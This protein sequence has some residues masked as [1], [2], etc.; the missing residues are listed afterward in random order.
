MNEPRAGDGGFIE[1]K[2]SRFVHAKSSQPIRFWAVNGP[3]GNTPEELR[4]EAK[5]LSK[6]GV[7]MVRHHHSRFDADG[8]LDPKLVRRTFDAV[9]AYKN[10]GIYSH[11]SLYFPLWLAPKPGNAWLKGYDGQ[12]HP[13]AALYFNKDFQ[14][15]YRSWIDALLL[16]PAGPKKTRLI[17]DPAVAGF[18]LINEDSYFFWTFDSNSIPDAE[19]RIIETQFADWLKAQ[20]GSLD[21]VLRRWKNQTTPRDAPTEGRLGM[22][23]LWNIAN[24]KSPRD[25]DTARFL[26]ESQRNFY[27]DMIKYLRSIGFK[28]MITASNW[29]TASAPVLGPLEKYSYTNGDFLDRHGYFG[30]THTGEAA[31]WSIR[32]GHTLPSIAP[33]CGSI[34]NEPG[35]Q[36]GCSTTRSSTPRTTASRR[37][38]PR[39]PGTGPTGSAPRPRSSSPATDRSRGP[40][41]SSISRSMARA[42]RSSPASSCSRGRS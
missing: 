36:P 28:G 4:N 30:C 17:D 10:E 41:R 21:A 18:E 20:Y 26:V 16:T 14:K 31:D 6:H 42:G 19:L 34:P 7:N 35:K 33:P 12:K 9:D 24:E 37:C 32:D 3:A 22:R 39:P 40:T 15:L 8:K 29:Q 2:G 1:A 38:F 11:L 5:V 27:A 13:F 25:K 23:P